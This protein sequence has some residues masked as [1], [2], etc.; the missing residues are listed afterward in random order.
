[1]SYSDFTIETLKEKLGV[2]LV[3][4]SILFPEPPSYPVPT[5]LTELLQRYVPLA[6]FINTEKARSELIIA[7]IL[8]ELKFHVQKKI[9]LF[10]GTEFNVDQQAGLTGRCD[11][12][13]S[14]SPEQLMLSAPVII[15]VEAKNENIMSGIPQCIATMIAAMRFNI[16]KGNPIETIYGIVTTGNL[17]RFLKLDCDNHAYIDTMEYHIQRINTIWSIVNAIIV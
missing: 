15:V 12:I 3:E 1:M 4:D 7:P 2:Y 11:Y 17:W 16:Q 9:S 13:I 5:F 8:V 10:S 6:T 14:L